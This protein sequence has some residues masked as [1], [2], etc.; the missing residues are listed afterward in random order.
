MAGFDE[1]ETLGPG[2]FDFP[3]G[4]AAFHL[5]ST[6][7][8]PVLYAATLSGGGVGAFVPDG[9][10]GLAHVGS[11]AWPKALVAGIAPAMAG[12]PV[13]GADALLFAGLPGA[14]LVPGPGGAPQGWTTFPSGELSGALAPAGAGLLLSAPPS[15]GLAVLGSSGAG[16]VRLS[17]VSGPPV[18]GIAR[19]PDGSVH[20][21]SSGAD[22]VARYAL[23]PAGT[24]TPGQVAGALDGLGWSAPS[25]IRATEAGGTAVL[26]VAAAG[27]SSLTT[28][29]LDGPL[30]RIADH[31]VDD[32]LTR[33]DG[34]VA[35]DAVTVA[36]R[37]IVAAGGADDGVSVFELLPGGRLVHLQSFEDTPA[38]ALG[39]VSA[40]AL[41]R[42]G[43]Q[44]QLA[45]AGQEGGITV[46]SRPAASLAPPILGGPGNDILRGGAADDLIMGRAGN[47]DLSG[48]AGDD[49]LVDGAGS[50]RMR[51]GAGADVF[52]FASD[53]QPDRVE[54]F[55]P[56]TDRLDLSAFPLLYAVSSLTVT[57]VAGGARIVYG[58]EVI[59]LR[60]ADGR[61]LD[62]GDLTEADVLGVTRPPL[63]PIGRDLAGTAGPDVLLGAGASDRLRGLAGD[64]D[65]D[66]GDGRDL[67][68]GGAGADRIAGGPGSDLILGGPGDDRLEGGAG[69]DVIAGGSG[70]D[71]ID[72]GPGNDTLR[73]GPGADVFVFAPRSG[74]DR[75]ADFAPGTDRLDLSAH[76]GFGSWAEVRSALSSV[77][78]GTVLD[79]GGGTL[80][81]LTGIDP[82]RLSA[83]DFLF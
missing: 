49:L 58:D 18:A 22:S 30:Y 47:D 74:I 77:P 33:F 62:A 65:I 39:N 68:S 59:V 69:A 75:I 6:S 51:G 70:R 79:L 54:D 71:R 60:T 10:G 50:D 81:L 73:G 52:V 40:V 35:L 24:L 67:A 38:R 12:F 48:G 11:L 9:A 31:I 20:A 4:I 78:G 57:P 72:G 2:E 5:G 16:P 21:I 76:P 34:V 56:G 37:T 83:G 15:G 19:L 43:A 41:F 63:V 13:N 36:G 29:T 3:F 1:R 28:L 17:A 42:S 64:D 8:A 14:A 25:A 61:A 82:A 66:G 45:V 26:V 44:L 80:V 23:S 32:R 27:S 53:G 46:F 55:E 7:A